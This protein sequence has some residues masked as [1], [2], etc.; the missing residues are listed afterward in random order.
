M[1]KMSKTEKLCLGIADLDDSGRSRLLGMIEEFAWT[2]KNSPKPCV[3][4]HDRFKTTV[5][6]YRQ[7]A[8]KKFGI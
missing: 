7:E 6:P 1:R 2:A 8:K 4:T 5:H 3:P